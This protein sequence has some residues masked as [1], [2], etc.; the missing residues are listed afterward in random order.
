MMDAPG[1]SSADLTAETALVGVLHIYVALD[2]GDEVDLERARRLAPAELLTLARRSRTPSSISYRPLPL[3][4]RLPPLPL[5]LA[6][7]GAVQAEAEATVF[8]FGG[9]SLALRVP[10][11]LSPAALLRLAGS[12]SEPARIVE[13]ARR[14][15]APLFEQLK[16]AIQQPAVSDLSE[17]YFVFQLVPGEPWSDVNRLLSSASAWAPAWCGWRTSHWEP[18]RWPKP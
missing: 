10:L 1:P 9:L 6:E 18:T 7:L 12:L 11:K 4:F 3:R 15:I 5:E 14:A 2:W 8:D 16:P 13:A 17:E